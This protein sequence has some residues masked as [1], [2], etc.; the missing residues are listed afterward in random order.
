MAEE[1]ITPENLTKEMLKEALDAAFMETCYDRDGDLEVVDGLK[2]FVI[3]NKE[4]KDRIHLLALFGLRPET[5]ELQRLQ[6]ANRINTE[7]FVVRAA[8]GENDT[9]LFTWDIPVAGGITQKAFV[10]AVRRFCSIPHK[11]I[12]NCAKDIVT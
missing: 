6:A 8:L 10:L 9:M 11:A 7:Y 2:C 12:A 4:R 3:P 1:L 5:T